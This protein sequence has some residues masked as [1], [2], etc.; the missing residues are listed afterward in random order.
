[1]EEAKNACT[2]AINLDPNYED[3]YYNRACYR[4]RLAE[5]IGVVFEDLR[6]AIELNPENRDFALEDEDFT[7]HP[8]FAQMR[9]LVERS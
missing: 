9:E 5:D 6:A 8:N 2:A 3:A 4:S 7:V 1:M